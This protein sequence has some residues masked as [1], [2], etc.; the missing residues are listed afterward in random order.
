MARPMEQDVEEF[1]FDLLSSRLAPKRQI[2]LYRT[3]LMHW[4]AV[5]RTTASLAAAASLSPAAASA[6]SAS[7]TSSEIATQKL[8]SVEE[9]T[10]D[11]VDQAL[12]S[13]GWRAFPRQVRERTLAPLE[14][15]CRWLVRQGRLASNPLISL[16]AGARRHPKTRRLRA[17]G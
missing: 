11:L 1:L 13:I 6:A 9:L 12:Q 17:S 16:Q 15:F 4:V 8:F 2:N 7:V 14:V 5:F 10:A 3:E